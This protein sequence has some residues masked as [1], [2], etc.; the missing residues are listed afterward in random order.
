MLHKRKD[1]NS[2]NNKRTPRL[3][4]RIALRR[5]NHLLNLNK[6]PQPRLFLLELIQDYAL[7][8]SRLALLVLCYLGAD[9]FGTRHV[10]DSILLEKIWSEG[11]FGDEG[12]DLTFGG[13]DTEVSRHV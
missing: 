5:H 8:F 2:P 10:T 12:V 1:L 9:G 6:L 7:R 4:L 3:R 11:E 13:C